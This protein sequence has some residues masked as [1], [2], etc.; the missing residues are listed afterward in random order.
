MQKKNWY[1]LDFGCDQFLK[2]QEQ[3]GI[4]LTLMFGLSLESIVMS[5]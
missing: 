2:I 4:S 3:K 5:L 1:R